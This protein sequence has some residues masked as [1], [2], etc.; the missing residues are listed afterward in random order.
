[1]YIN[2]EFFKRNNLYVGAVFNK[3][4]QMFERKIFCQKI[5]DHKY[6][7]ILYDA[8]QYEMLKSG[9]QSNQKYAIDNL[10]KL[11]EYL[12]WLGVIGINKKMSA[13]EFKKVYYSALK[14][15]N[16]LYK[17]A[18]LFEVRRVERGYKCLYAYVRD[19]SRPRPLSYKS[20]KDLEQ[21]LEL[22]TKPTYEEIQNSDKTF[23]KKMF[24][25]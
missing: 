20:F 13:A 5:N 25:I 16:K 19:D 10:I 14:D 17:H 1:M 24:L 9:E 15:L 18:G 21:V 7:D 8:P 11:E 12:F 23:K 3:D 2:K 22:P 6:E 4:S